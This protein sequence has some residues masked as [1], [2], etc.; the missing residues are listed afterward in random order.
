MKLVEQRGS[1]RAVIDAGDGLRVALVLTG[2]QESASSVSFFSKIPIL[3]AIAILENRGVEFDVETT[4]L[5]TRATFR[6]PDNNC[7]SLYSE[8]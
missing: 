5:F 7:L 1:T 6:D 4:E 2:A 8:R 3:E